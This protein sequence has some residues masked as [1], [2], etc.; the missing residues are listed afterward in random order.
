MESETLE[1]CWI[2][3][4]GILAGWLYVWLLEPRLK[5]LAAAAAAGAVSW[6]AYR[7]VVCWAAAAIASAV[8]LVSGS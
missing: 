2:L 6:R 1:Y 8:A 5:R 3:V 7:G 4:K